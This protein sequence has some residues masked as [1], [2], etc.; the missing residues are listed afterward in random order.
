MSQPHNTP[1]EK[2]PC[3]P[4]LRGQVVLITGGGTGIGRGA[5]LRL[6]AEGMEVTICGRRQDK[7]AETVALVEAA[8]GEI[9]A[10]PADVGSPEDVHRVVANILER[11]GF[12]DALVHNAML[13]NFSPFE[14]HT[15][16]LWESSFATGCRGAYL[17][18][19]EIVPSMRDR[20]RGNVV[21]ITSVL[22][23]RSGK[24]GLSY[25][26]VKGAQEAMARHM[27]VT[28]AADG[29]RVNS[30]APGLIYTWGDAAEANLANEHV[31]LGRAGTPAE[32]AAVVAFLLSD[33]SSYITGQVIHA[34]GGTSIQLAPPSIRL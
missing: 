6:A 31:P 30:L 15:L 27:A 5:A 3:Y 8:G 16:E 9:H 17:L 14:K 34:D 10:E 33:Q 23:Q 21:F 11:F 28:W 32:M 24:G 13:M 4:D 29:I 25:H 19:K 7:L 2:P 20:R 1:I 26:A 22:A 18:A 12:V